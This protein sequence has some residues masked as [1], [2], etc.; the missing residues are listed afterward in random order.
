MPA[1]VSRIRGLAAVPLG[2]SGAVRGDLVTARAAELRPDPVRS[3]TSCHDL[4]AEPVGGP[5]PS[6]TEEAEAFR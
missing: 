3:S 1:E 4:V 2:A 6:V 5:E